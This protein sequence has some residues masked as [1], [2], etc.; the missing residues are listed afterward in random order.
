MA[1][2]EK[3]SVLSRCLQHGYKIWMG[4]I[5]HTK[6]LEKGRITSFLSQK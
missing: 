1:Y 4:I 3:I 2:Q 6:V 5:L